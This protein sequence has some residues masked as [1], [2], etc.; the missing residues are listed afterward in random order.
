MKAINR[1]QSPV[2]EESEEEQY[3]SEETSEEED[4]KDGDSDDRQETSESEQS[5]HGPPKKSKSTFHI[6]NWLFISSLLELGEIHMPFSGLKYGFIV[7]LNWFISSYWAYEKFVIQQVEIGFNDFNISNN[8]RKK[9]INK[10]VKKKPIPK[11]VI[12]KETLFIN[13]ANTRYPII[14]KAAKSLGFK[15]TYKEEKDWDIIW[16]D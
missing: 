14:K 10:A 1:P 12:K 6:V 4:S 9:L 13:V 3:N 16:Y 2:E 7:Y 11:L 15:V 8:Y 5:E